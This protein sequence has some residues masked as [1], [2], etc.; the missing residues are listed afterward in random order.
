MRYGFVLPGGPAPVQLEQAEVAEAAG[1]D[2]LFVWEGPYG[3]DAWSLLAAIAVRTRR[4]RLGTMLTPLPWRR[5]WKVAAQAATLDQLS[6]GRAILAVGLGA[7][8]L[9]EFGEDEDRRRRAELLDDGIDLVRALWRG[10]SAFAGSR[11]G[12]DLG[13]REDFLRLGTPVQEPGVPI[14]VVGVW[15]RPKSL[16]RVLRAD[17]VLPMYRAREGPSRSLTPADV[18]EMA[19]WLEAHGGRP[20][21][22]DIVV[23]GET[24]AARGAAGEIVSPWAEAGATWWLDTRWTLPDGDERRREVRERL[25]AGPPAYS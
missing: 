12:Y 5:P 9:G 16:R 10:E 1:W 6:G 23:E 8:G 24:P 18:R 20:A 17:G 2:G 4:L 14:W 25:E 15:P 19:A 22:F 7:M 11:L 3:F 13:E 21:G